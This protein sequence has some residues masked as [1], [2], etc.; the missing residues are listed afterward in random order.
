MSETNSRLDAADLHRFIHQTQ[1]A[2]DDQIQIL[3]AATP[4]FILDA[5]TTACWRFNEGYGTSLRDEV[6]DLTGTLTMGGGSW[7]SDKNGTALLFDNAASASLGTQTAYHT[8]ITTA[9]SWDAIVAVI[10]TAALQPLFNKT[11]AV[12]AA[13]GNNTVR[14]DIVSGTDVRFRG[15]GATTVWDVTAAGV[16]Q[17]GR[18]HHIRCI[19]DNAHASQKQRIYVN[20][21]SAAVATGNTNAGNLNNT[22]VQPSRFGI[23]SSGGSDY[24]QA[25]LYEFRISSILRTE[26]LAGFVTA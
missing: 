7:H 26:Q 21:M 11:V 25:K 9:G 16:L 18:L 10:G 14:I 19:Y 5:A 12:W 2:L 4:Y 15:N 22:A 23:D 6:N 1:G 24:L 3:R 8:G 20:D 17:V 13:D